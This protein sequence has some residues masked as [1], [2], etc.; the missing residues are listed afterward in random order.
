GIEQRGHP[1][2]E[3]R[4]S[5]EESQR[6]PHRQTHPRLRLGLTLSYPPFPNSVAVP[7]W[8][9]PL[10]ICSRSRAKLSGP[11]M[12]R[13]IFRLRLGKQTLVLGRRTVIMGVLNITPDSFSDGGQFLEPRAAI[14]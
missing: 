13:K 11:M 3:I 4:R 14:Q 1:R 12:Q 2:Q 9:I 7:R 10:S 8:Q 5:D 6:R